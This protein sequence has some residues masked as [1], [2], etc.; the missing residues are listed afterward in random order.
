MPLTVLSNSGRGLRITRRQLLLQRI[1]ANPWWANPQAAGVARATVRPPGFGKL[2]RSRD[3]NVAPRA[4]VEDVAAAVAD[5][6]V[7]AVPT[8]QGVGSGRADYHVV[9]VFTVG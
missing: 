9:A 7:V 6:H 2:G 1:S 5:Q 4:A 3:Q 8:E